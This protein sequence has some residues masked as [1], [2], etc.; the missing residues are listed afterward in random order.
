[1]GA[2]N[3]FL[4]CTLA[5]LVLFGCVSPTVENQ[6]ANLTTDNGSSGL[7]DLGQ[8]NGSDVF[9]NITN[10]TPTNYLENASEINSTPVKG[11]IITNINTTGGIRT[12]I[13]QGETD[14]REIAELDLSERTRGCPHEV[15]GNP[16]AKLNIKYFWASTC[17]WCARFDAYLPE[18]IQE[19]GD[20]FAMERY[21]V[22]QCTNEI[23]NYQVTSTPTFILSTNSTE[24]TYLIGFRSIEEMKEIVCAY[25]GGCA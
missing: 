3:L 25:S 4:V 9:Y 8:I 5:S 20:L 21:D 19:K 23:L 12:I 1:M 14:V 10:G 24:G 22:F 7:L 6:T 18:L 2:F 11:G 16:S 13:W 15:L 17:P